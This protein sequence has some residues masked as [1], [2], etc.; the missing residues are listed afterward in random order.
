MSGGIIRVELEWK[1]CV[2]I[3]VAIIVVQNRIRVSAVTA[4]AIRRGS[5]L[6]R[7]DEL[8]CRSCS[9]RRHVY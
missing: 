2:R 5:Y 1:L 7:L 4:S 9:D 6:L 3:H 8:L